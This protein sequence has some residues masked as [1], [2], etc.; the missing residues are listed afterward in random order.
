[1]KTNGWNPKISGLC[2]CFSAPFLG[3]PAVVSTTQS[4]E[5]VRK[6]VGS[7]SAGLLNV[8]ESPV[9]PG[10]CFGLTNQIRLEGS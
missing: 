2:Q 9:Q 3:E 5:A 10:F 4:P 6:L 7:R 1:M 8:G